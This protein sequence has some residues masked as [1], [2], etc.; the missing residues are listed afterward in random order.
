MNNFQILDKLKD[1][2]VTVCSAD[3]VRYIE[4]QFVISNTQTSDQP[5]EH[6]VTFYFPRDEPCEFFD[7]MGNLPEY[8]DV[9]FEDVLERTKY[10]VSTDQIQDSKSDICGLYCIY[11]VMYRHA[12]IGMKELLSIFDVFQKKRNDVLVMEKIRQ[13]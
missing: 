8:Y 2:P 5:G 12:G 13:K 10:F 1:Y 7:S 3:Q 4:G 9:G 6:W 11:Y